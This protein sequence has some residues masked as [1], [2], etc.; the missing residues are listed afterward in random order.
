M[1]AGINFL[2]LVFDGF[3]ESARTSFAG[4]GLFGTP[5]EQRLALLDLKALL[6]C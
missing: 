5:V 4:A 2:A 1:S 6:V 3:I